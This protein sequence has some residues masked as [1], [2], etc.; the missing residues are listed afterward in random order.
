MCAIF[1]WKGKLHAWKWDSVCRPKSGGG[2]GLR[3]ANDVNKAAQLKRFWNYCTSNSIW[4]SWLREHYSKGKSI[5]E[6]HTQPMDFYVWKNIVDAR[7]LSSMHMYQ[8]NTNK[9]EWLASSNGA[10]TL[11]S[12][13]H[14]VRSPAPQFDLVDV[15]WFPG[16]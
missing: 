9:W 14:I 2:V 13:W 5:W 3:K 15:T 12:A 6:I 4:A 16:L 7:Q 11:A 8:D 10:F 1:L